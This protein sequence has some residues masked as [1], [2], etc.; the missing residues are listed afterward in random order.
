MFRLLENSVYKILWFPNRLTLTF[1]VIEKF[2]N[3]HSYMVEMSPL[4]DII[5]I[6]TSNILI[7]L[8]VREIV[9]LNFDMQINVH[10]RGNI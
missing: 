10:K 4:V 6:E 3:M 1:L 2:I 5:Y 8:K 7:H 9:S